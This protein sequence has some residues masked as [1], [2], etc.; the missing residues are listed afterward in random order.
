MNCEVD[1]VSKELLKTSES[2]NSDKC[3]SSIV[4]IDIYFIP[5]CII[6]ILY[7]YNVLYL[8]YILYA[9]FYTFLIMVM[10]LLNFA[11]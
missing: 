7:S 6:Y 5:P 2:Q 11:E 9:T 8:Y 4:C 3:E 1:G 10:M